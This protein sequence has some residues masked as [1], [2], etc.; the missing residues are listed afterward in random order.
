MEGWVEGMNG[1]VCGRILVKNDACMY[2]WI[3]DM[4]WMYGWMHEL[5]EGGYRWVDGL[6]GVWAGGRIG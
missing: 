6:L 2:A 5:V 1:W 3:G 4:E